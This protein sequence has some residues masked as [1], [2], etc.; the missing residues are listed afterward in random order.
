MLSSF[1][2][3]NFKSFREAATLEFAPLTA[4]IGANASGQSNALEA[5]RLLSW[6]AQGHRLDSVRYVLRDNQHAIRDAVRDLGHGGGRAFSLS[7]RTICPEWDRYS[8]GFAV[9]EEGE[10]RVAEEKLAG[11]TQRAPLFKT[12]AREERTGELRVAYNNFLRG[13]KKPQ[14]HCIDREPVLI[15]MQSPARFHNRHKKAREVVPAVA[16]R[17]RAWLSYIFFSIRVPRRYGRATVPKPIEFRP[18]TETIFPAFCTACTT[19]WIRGTR[20]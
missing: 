17:Y 13:G 1:T 4:P 2:I 6:A 5:L 10:L 12:V 8:I 15:Q 19:Q 7:C 3:E 14:I 16:R 11:A 18:R 20:F 9:D